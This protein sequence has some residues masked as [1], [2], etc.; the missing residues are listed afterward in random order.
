MY[1]SFIWLISV[2]DQYYHRQIDPTGRPLNYSYHAYIDMTRDKNWN[3][4][5]Y[6]AFYLI[7][8]SFFLLSLM[9]VTCYAFIKQNYT[10]LLLH[11]KRV[12]SCPHRKPVSVIVY[13]MIWYVTIDQIPTLQTTLKCQAKLPL[14]R[15]SFIFVGLE[16]IN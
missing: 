9:L 12:S 2:T 4:S 16:K 5:S 6:S 10:P 13:C 11:N 14:Y 15:C 3:Q 8:L 7:Y 1:L